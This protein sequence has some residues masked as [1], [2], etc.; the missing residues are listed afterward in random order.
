MKYETMDLTIENA[1]DLV[2]DLGCLLAGKIF[3]DDKPEIIAII[4]ND[5]GII[6]YALGSDYANQIAISLNHNPDLA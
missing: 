4:D 5:V 1:G 3:S 6:G 2:Y